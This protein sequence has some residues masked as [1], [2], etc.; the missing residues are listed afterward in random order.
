MVILE[1]LICLWSLLF[2][3]SILWFTSSRDSEF[4]CGYLMVSFFGSLI[5]S[6]G[7]RGTP[8]RSHFGAD[9]D[10]M[11]W[12][13]CF[14][15]CILFFWI[16]RWALRA[17]ELWTAYL[18]GRAIAGAARST[19]PRAM[20][21]LAGLIA[22]GNAQ[23]EAVMRESLPQWTSTDQG[24]AVGM[25]VLARLEKARSRLRK[26]TAGYDYD[27]GYG[28]WEPV[29]VDPDADRRAAIDRTTTTLRTHLGQGDEHP[30]DTDQAQPEPTRLQG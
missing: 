5:V 3:S 15:I 21:R 20:F 2:A 22:H 7:M 4:G 13:V 1:G 6:F 29:T 12:I 23:A 9:A 25:A 18:N 27:V 17:A 24:Q 10:F 26:P 19:D 16:G 11:L 8:L 30:G 14:D 28:V